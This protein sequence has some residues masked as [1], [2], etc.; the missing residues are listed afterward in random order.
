MKKIRGYF[1]LVIIICTLA[2]CNRSQP[3]SVK[4]DPYG[5]RALRIGII[6]K[7][8]EVRERQVAF[9]KIKFSDLKKERFDSQY[10]SIFIT[11]DNLSEAAQEKYK[12]IYKKS[13]I[14]FFFIQSKKGYVPFI[15]EKLSYE[16]VPDMQ[17]LTYA[18]GIIFNDNKL[19]Y[20]GYGLYNDIENQD[21][22]KD[23]YSRIFETISK[24]KTSE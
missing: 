4:T 1:L 24:N 18:T 8:P 2:G 10:D 16:E 5:G 14:P 12:P 6:G 9:V 11:K 20:W 15:V 7:I 23:V 21:N 19:K 17:D 3:Q 22:I 13:K